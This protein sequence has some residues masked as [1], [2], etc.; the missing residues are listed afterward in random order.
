MTAIGKKAWLSLLVISFTCALL[1]LAKAGNEQAVIPIKA[2]KAGRRFAQ[3]LGV[4]EVSWN[5][6]F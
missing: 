1:P 6:W 3:S 5:K 4:E 2:P